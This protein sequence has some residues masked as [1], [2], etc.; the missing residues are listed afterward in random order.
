[1][2]APSKKVMLRQ[3]DIESIQ[4]AAKIMVDKMQDAPTIEQLATRVGLN[5]QKLKKG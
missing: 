2:K 1:M 5:R 4:K 3:Y